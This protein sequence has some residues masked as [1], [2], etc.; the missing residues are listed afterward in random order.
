[1]SPALSAIEMAESILLDK[2]RVLACA[3]LCEGE[4]GV[5]GLF[6]GVPC[7]L[8]AKGVERILEVELDPAERKL[9]DA[10]LEHVRK[11]V[12]EIRL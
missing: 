7:V 9:F 8:G 12:D 6:V 1:V 5:Q 4:Y 2:K 3:C 11:L 10:S